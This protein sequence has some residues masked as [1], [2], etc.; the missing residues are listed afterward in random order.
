MTEVYFIRHAQSDRLYHDER[1]RPLTGEGLADSEKLAEILKDKGIAHI[2][3]SPYTRTL[4]TVEGLAKTLGLEIETNEELRERHA[5][6]WHGDRFF[7]FIEKQ[8]NDFDYSIEGGESLRE[9]QKRNIKALDGLLKK[10]K[11]ETVAIATHGTA[12]STIINYFYPKYG[13]EDFLKIADLMPL[14]IRTELD[15]KSDG[16]MI[17]TDIKEIF[18][19]HR[20]Y[21]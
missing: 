15:V 1:T 5:G 14:V 3:S 10:Y 4:Q 11:N 13:F 18:S 19:V 17:C 12:L 21:K 2:I 16:G 7:D 20:A 8:W 9:V 6:K